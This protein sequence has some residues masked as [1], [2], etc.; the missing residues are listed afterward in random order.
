MNIVVI[1][2]GYVGLVTAACFS[3]VGHNVC[4]IDMDR[5]KINKLKIGE[6]P[7]SEPGLDQLVYKSVSSK[8]LSFT[9]SYK[10]AFSNKVDSVFMCVGTPPNKNRSP[11]LTFLKKSI[12]SIA[13]YSKGEIPIFIKS[14]VPAGTNKK[15]K[16]YYLKFKNSSN[17]LTF[18]S[19]PEFLKEGDAINDFMQPDRIIIGSENTK[20]HAIAKEAYAS[21]I[22]KKSPIIFTSVESAEL[23]KYSANAFL[24]TKISFI[25]EISRLSE[26]FNADILEIQKGIGLD[27]RIG[28]KFLSAGIGFGGSCFPKDLDG[29]IYNF[30]NSN[31]AASIPQASKDT[32]L[33]QLMF[34]YKKI[35]KLWNYKGK[36]ILVW[37]L[38]FKPGT[39][40]I[41]ESASIKLVRL[42]A[43]QA[44]N[45]YLY[46]PEAM[47][48]S[49]IELRDIK[50]ITF[51]NHKYEMIDLIDGLIICTEWD[52]FKAPIIKEIS[53]L[54]DQIIFD[55]R[56]IL[57]KKS[58]NNRKIKY[59][60]VGR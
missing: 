33:E 60:G 18:A 51:L 10:Q 3:D 57:D 13:K 1:G 41:R 23:I 37:G 53:K 27:S 30:K 56:N 44:K 43:K 24:A 16:K 35:K 48:N 26:C 19:N 54:K 12:E 6:I 55:G 50:N 42:L 4:C 39:D 2:S 22:S 32:N 46:D 25:N 20:V 38:S 58:L 21:I 45:L 47:S 49:K 14:T 8:N 36:N 28:K 31:I 5:K 29:L 17:Q 11:D 34:F 40:D 52:E 9:T 59:Y 15:L 7:F